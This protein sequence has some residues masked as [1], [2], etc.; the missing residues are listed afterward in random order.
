MPLN[1]AVALAP[2]SLQARTVEDGHAAV[3]VLDQVSVF[4]RTSG[5]G[6]TGP[7]NPQHQ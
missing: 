1:I 2:G 7:P 5:D 4:Q 3:R 6:H